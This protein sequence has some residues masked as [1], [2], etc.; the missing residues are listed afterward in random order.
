[1]YVIYYSAKIWNLLFIIQDGNGIIQEF[2]L[3][4]QLNFNT[5]K[6]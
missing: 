2:W 3:E 1:M 6:T 4:K 5:K